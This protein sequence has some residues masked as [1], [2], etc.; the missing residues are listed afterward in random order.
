MINGDGGGR[1]GDPR[2]IGEAVAQEGKKCWKKLFQP[3][4]EIIFKIAGNRFLVKDGGR[5]PHLLRSLLHWPLSTIY[6]NFTL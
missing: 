5:D 4:I 1:P 3:G 2:L 6:F